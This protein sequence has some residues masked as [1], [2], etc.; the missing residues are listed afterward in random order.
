MAYG[1]K[2]YSTSL[3]GKKTIVNKNKVLWIRVL[4]GYAKINKYNA[5]EQQNLKRTRAKVK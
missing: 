1:L 3:G 4:D 5:A 2:S